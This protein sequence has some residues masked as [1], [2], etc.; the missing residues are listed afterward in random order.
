MTI[1]EE[2]IEDLILSLALALVCAAVP[3]LARRVGGWVLGGG[4]VVGVAASVLAA[5][6]ALPLYPWSDLLVA[7]VAL[8]GG[9]LLGRALPPR[10]RPLL[11]PLLV[12]SA[13]DIAQ[14]ALTGGWVPLAAIPLAPH[15]ATP[16]GPLLYGNLILPL[17]GDTY[18]VGIFDLLVI[19]AIAEHL[20][21]RGGPYL[22]AALPSV[23]G[24][25]LAYAAVWLTQL[26]GWPLLPFFT[27]GWLGIE[28][29]ARVR[30]AGPKSARA[31]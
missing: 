18:K 1:N 7:L 31:W 15:P 4:L 16:S 9:L 22:Y 19:T 17:R 20:R 3:W 5:V 6:L 14:I 2:L 28:V 8:S 24:F 29:I 25:A 11:I 23:L 12:L 21:R 13:L 26:G 27:I 30:G 10:F